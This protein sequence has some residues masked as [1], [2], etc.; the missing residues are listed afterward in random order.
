MYNSYR[1]INLY[2]YQAPL[3]VLEFN[4]HFYENINLAFQIFS[5]SLSLESKHSMQKVI[6]QIVKKL[7]LEKNQLTKLYQREICKYKLHKKKL[8]ALPQLS[9]VICTWTYSTFLLDI[10]QILCC[11]PVALFITLWFFTIMSV[12]RIFPMTV[13]FNKGWESMNQIVMMLISAKQVH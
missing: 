6:S 11:C 5:N 7:I 9:V 2:L 10:G 8:L 12:T 1:I 13:I 4:C 3:W